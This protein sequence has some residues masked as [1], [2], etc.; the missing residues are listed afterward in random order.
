MSDTLVRTADISTITS[1]TRSTLH[2]N[3]N[4]VPNGIILKYLSSEIR[5]RQMELNQLLSKKAICEEEIKVHAEAVKSEDSTLIV[6]QGGVEFHSSCVDHLCSRPTAP[7]SV[8]QGSSNSGTDQPTSGCT[9]YAFDSQMSDST[10]QFDALLQSEMQKLSIAKEIRQEGYLQLEEPKTQLMVRE[11]RIEHLD[12]L[13]VTLNA[14][15]RELMRLRR[16]QLQIPDEVW[17]KIFSVARD[18]EF[19]MY[20]DQA[21]QLFFIPFSLSFSQVCQRWRYIT[22]NESSLWK[23]IP[24]RL[25]R[26][27]SPRWVEMFSFMLDRIRGRRVYLIADKFHDSMSRPLSPTE[28]NHVNV[29][30]LDI[31]RT[32]FNLVILEPPPNFDLRELS[33]QMGFN[34][35]ERVT[36]FGNQYNRST[37]DVV[38][39]DTH[40]FFLCDFFLSS[41]IVAPG[42]THVLYLYTAFSGQNID[43]SPYMLSSLRE[44]TLCGDSIDLPDNNENEISLPELV[45]LCISP[46]QLGVLKRLTAPRLTTLILDPPDR[47]SD[48]FKGDWLSALLR[49]SS[50]CSFIKF[51]TWRR[52]IFDTPL[53][54]YWS[55]AAV[56]LEIVKGSQNLIAVEFLDSIVDGE[57]LVMGLGGFIAP[58]L[59]TRVLNEMIFNRCTGITR[60]NCEALM[61][62]VSCLRIMV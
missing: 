45:S 55:A 54:P 46:I 59:G 26:H 60:M 20:R 17:I 25:N 31:R 39:P 12:R 62:I 37:G 44:L 40:E 41:N 21:R 32:N 34:S 47:Y 50:R 7:S 23:F 52:P 29:G 28:A 49:V 57:R 51:D 61:E 9:T 56:C 2:F 1:A 13:M 14:E 10:R 5:N 15:I 8:L 16:P 18:D 22:H 33:H 27:W 35:F 42:T 53:P 3:S 6:A 19:E 58:G 30:T 48:V 38:L 11:R 4:Q 43:A 24:F 36:I